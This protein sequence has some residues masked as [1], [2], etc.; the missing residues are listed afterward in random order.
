MERAANT[1]GSS[2]HLYEALANDL[3]RLVSKGTLR[4]GDRLPSVRQ[5]SDQRGVSVSTVLQ[6]YLLL[7]NRGIVET[8]PQS[9]HY[10][11][12]RRLSLVAEP[13]TPRGATQATRVSVTE[14]IARVYSASRDPRNVLLG[15]GFMSP[16]LL[17]TESL[18][19]RLAAVARAAGGA[20]IAYDPPPGLPAL[21][22]AIARR[23]ADY[24]VA[25]SA[26]DVVTT[27][28]TME[29]L[30]LC[31]RA[32]ARH[33]D[34]IVVE[35]PAY[36]GVL[37]LIES[38]GMR[39]LEVPSNA[40]TG[41]DLAR[42]QEA[43]RQHPVRAVLLVPTFSNPL[44]ALMPDDTKRELV[45]ML[46]RHE[47]P[48]IE[49]DIYGDLGFDAAR[50][51]PAKAFDRHGLVM[52]CTSFSKTLA[53]GY[54]VGWV[55]P[56]RWR[57]AVERLKFA[58]TVGTPTLPQMAIADFLENGGY[59]RHLRR[60]R[61]SLADQVG[62]VS[63]AVAEHFPKGTRISRP[64]GGFLLWV[65]MPPGKNALDLHDRALARGV[66]IAPGPIFSA[67]QRFSN[68]LR[69]SCAWPWSDRIERAIRTLGELARGN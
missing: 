24:D 47:V 10:V 13:R 14:L 53:P 26:D 59:E 2:G 33:G 48:L 66:S 44:G 56:G 63:D 49:D 40:G 18:N 35:S 42:L 5:L 58:Q 52:L 39:V 60:L 57:D 28:G 6:A 27:V 29:A 19:R 55:A 45:R 3:A 22:R 30:H 41:V 65:E 21:R 16:E 50:P 51:R 62:R 31:L 36:Y 43:L 38:L 4:P 12:A 7:E 17:P 37:Q 9:G 34:T 46:A 23:A 68:C 64:R 32:V 20:G 25:L 69:L 54:R 8:R 67:K 11:R 61:R 15:G 1:N